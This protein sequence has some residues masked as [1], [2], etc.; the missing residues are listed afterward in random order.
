MTPVEANGWLKVKGTYLTNSRGDTVQLRGVAS[1]GLQWFS[2]FYG[3]GAAFKAAAEQWGADVI[4]LTLYLSEDGY[5]TS[6]TIT[7][8]Q[9]DTMLDDYVKACAAS[10]IYVILDWHVHKPG[11]PSYYQDQAKAFFEKMSAKYAAYPNVLYE[12][13]NEPSSAGLTTEQSGG[14]ATDP[15]HYVEW[16]EIAKYAQT[17]IPIIRK[18]SPNALVLVGTPSWSTLGVSTK[19]NDAWK[20]I[21]DKPLDFPNVLYVIHYY[22]GAHTFQSALEQASSRLPLFSTEWASSGFQETSSLDPAKGKAFV[23]MLNRRKISWCYWNFSNSTPGV[24]AMLDKTTTATGPFS[25]TGSNVTPTGR[26]VYDWL[27]TPAD[28]WK[29]RPTVLADRSRAGLPSRDANRMRFMEGRLLL[30]DPSGWF[31]IQPDGRMRSL[32]EPRKQPAP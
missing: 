15:G 31:G 12:I 32:P 25:P 24:F 5:L 14:T 6:K 4:R 9:F 13:C 21:A 1:H 2:E 26:L 20:E 19:G 22:A 8:A 23:D 27:N 7:Q 17:I 11:Y 16:S 30:W 29:D 3:Q 10:G 18:N 28:A